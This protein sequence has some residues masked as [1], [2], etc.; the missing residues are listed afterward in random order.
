MLNVTKIA[1]VPDPSRIYVEFER[2]GGQELAHKIFFL[3]DEQVLLSTQ[4]CMED[5]VSALDCN[6]QNS[7]K[8]GILN[9]LD[10]LLGR[11]SSANQVAGK[12]VNPVTEVDTSEGSD[13]T[14]A[15]PECT[16][17]DIAQ[18]IEDDDDDSEQ[19][20]LERKKVRDYLAS[21][22]DLQNVGPAALQAIKQK[23]EIFYEDNAIRPG[24]RDYIYDKRIDFN[25]DNLEPSD[26]DD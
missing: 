17:P 20:E 13:G 14:I 26:W 12:N 9:A 23:M 15:T 8:D 25:H 11:I 19:S 7:E 4:K 21:F 22:G 16:Q 18:A 5:I 6:L 2:E 1:A 10:W 3:N 24:H